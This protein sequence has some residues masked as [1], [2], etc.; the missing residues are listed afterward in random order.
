MKDF[1]KQLEEVKNTLPKTKEDAERN[2]ILS[3]R[4]SSCN[5][6]KVKKNLANEMYDLNVGIT[7]KELEILK[8]EE[9]E[10]LEVD[11]ENVKR[12]NDLVEVWKDIPGWEGIYQ[13]STKGRVRSL[14]R[15]V[16]LPNGVLRKHNGQLRKTSY[17]G[18][19]SVTA[20]VRLI[21]KKDGIEKHEDVNIIDTMGKVFIDPNQDKYY[22]IIG[23][24][25]KEDLYKQDEYGNYGYEKFF[26]LS[27]VIK[28]RKPKY[29]ISIKGEDTIF[30]SIIDMGNFFFKNIKNKESKRPTSIED[31]FISNAKK[32]YVGKD[33]EGYEY[34]ANMDY[35]IDEDM[36]IKFYYGKCKEN[37]HKR[38]ISNKI[39]KNGKI[40]DDEYLG[41]RFRP[42]DIKFGLKCIINDEKEDKEK[43]STAKK[44]RYKYFIN[45]PYS[46]NESSD[47]IIQKSDSEEKNYYYLVNIS[48]QE[49]IAKQNKESEK[50]SPKS[51]IKIE[52]TQKDMI[53]NTN[54]DTHKE[55]DKNMPTTKL[56]RVKYYYFLDWKSTS[57]VKDII[58]DK[59]VGSLTVTLTTKD[60]KEAMI[61]TQEEFD[62]IRTACKKSGSDNFNK[63]RVQYMN[64]LEIQ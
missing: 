26:N 41:I 15:Y 4:I 42:S 60:F 28:E 23:S 48:R 30:S 24:I 3:T 45:N 19:Q 56:E 37:L 50:S 47:Y 35:Q 59:E 34:I 29:A 52:E 31:F 2:R 36:V 63:L 55:G 44:M 20:Y 39:C 57:Y 64:V 25:S 16:E 53:S 32:I 51:P 17:N 8:K 10:I 58:F 43:V 5:Y 61:F 38:M 49:S 27:N 33:C 22:T 12:I 13:I 54:N 7:S 18:N 1:K 21:H 40:L 62:T 46:L 6:V 9:K 14:D 11:F